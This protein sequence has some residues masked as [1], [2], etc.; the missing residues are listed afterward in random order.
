L[1]QEQLVQRARPAQQE[2]RVQRVQRVQL[3]ALRRASQLVRR[4]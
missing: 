2:Q 1:L 4:S 3:D